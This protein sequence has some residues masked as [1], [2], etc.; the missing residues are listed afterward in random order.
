VTEQHTVTLLM[1]AFVTHDVKRLLVGRPPGFAFKPG[2]GVELSINR[3]GWTDKGRPFTPTSLVDDKVLEFTI[4]RYPEHEGVTRELHRLA[5]GTEL[6]LSEPFGT[7]NYQGPGVFIAGGAGITPFLAI[8]RE[9]ARREELDRNTLLF[10]NKRRVD[11]I[12]EKEL[13][14]YL[15]TRCILTCTAEDTPGYDK[16]HF[17]RAFLA[18][19]IRDF[20]QP[21]YVC[22]PP[23]FM[24]AVTGALEELG[25]D[26]QRLIFER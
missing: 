8:L 17:D 2:Q 7:I 3:P 6:L 18:E 21:F 9:L 1:S 4:K 24:E 25:A 14:H 16:R 22:G 19:M 15:D 23:G 11:I 10:S 13:R 26:P 12:C 5:P 20:S